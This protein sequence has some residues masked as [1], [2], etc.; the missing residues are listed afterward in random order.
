MRAASAAA[1]LGMLNAA[2]ELAAESGEPAAEVRAGILE[3]NAT[4]ET[5]IRRFLLIAEAR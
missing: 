2:E 5:M 1:G 3:M 4:L